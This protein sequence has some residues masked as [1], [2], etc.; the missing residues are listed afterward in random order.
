MNLASVVARWTDAPS[1]R[2][3]DPRRT[4]GDG[5]QSWWVGTRERGEATAV[6][7]GGQALEREAGWR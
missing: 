6:N 4:R 5:S 2:S 1:S 3:N 7:S